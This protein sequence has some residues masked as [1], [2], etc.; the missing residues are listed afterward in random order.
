MNAPELTSR[1]LLSYQ[2]G[3][4]ALALAVGLVCLWAFGLPTATKMFL[5]M[6]LLPQPFLLF[7][8]RSVL[9]AERSA[10]GS[11]APHDQSSSGESA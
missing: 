8:F 3:I 5:F 6:F 9:W 1:D 10:A 11:G 2:Y 7:A 4:A